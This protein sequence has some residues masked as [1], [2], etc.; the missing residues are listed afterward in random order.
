MGENQEVLF[1]KN[2]EKV[3][4]Q[5]REQGN[6]ISEQQVQE[7]FEGF[8]L[9][10]EQLLMVY[11]YLHQYKISIGDKS[12]F[13]LEL[14]DEDHNYLEEYEKELLLLEEPSEGEKEAL[15]LSAMAGE[16]QAQ[17]K[18]ITVFLTKVLE[19][20]KLYVGQG[21]FIEDLIG[22]GNVVLSLGASMLGCLETAQ[23]AEGMLVKMIM[24][25]M[26]ESINEHMQETQREQKVLDRVN[27]VAEKARELAQ[28]L[29]RKVTVQELADETGM[30]E[31][32]IRE[33]M[34]ISGNAIEDLE[35]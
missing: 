5:A 15:I 21:V 17:E 35:G 22:E 8:Q 13:D 26:E 34:R 33:A 23:E 6:S 25:A 9:S 27:K 4:K 7:I 2:L 16:T 10:D 3:K 11:D 14:S 19:I 29:Q 1:A 28:D 24:D 12:E 30:S 31:K 32:S 20:S 18:L